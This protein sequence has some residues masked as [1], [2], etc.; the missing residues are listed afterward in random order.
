MAGASWARADEPMAVGPPAAPSSAAGETAL[1]ATAPRAVTPLPAV[2]PVG[3]L[4][5]APDAMAK[6]ASNAP[7]PLA[8][9]WWFW[10]GLGAAAVAAVVTAIAISPREAYTGNTSPGL[11]QVF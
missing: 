5:V 2:A 7:V 3:A 10:A 8:R 6:K 4:L 1:G 11:V 9:R